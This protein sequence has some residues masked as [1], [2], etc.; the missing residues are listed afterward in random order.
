M[1]DGQI[2]VARQGAVAQ[3]RVLGRATFKISQELKQ[4][5]LKAVQQQNAKDIICDFS[6]CTALDST[7]MGVLAMLGL[8]SRG[9]CA[10]VFVNVSP[11]NRKLLDGLGVSRLF[12]FATEPVPEVT[13]S[14]LCTA[15][16]KTAAASRETAE[17]VLSAHQTLMNVDAGNIPKFRNVVDMLI[18][19]VE[20]LKKEGESS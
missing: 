2:L 5:C 11:A 20:Q 6:E 17:L 9:K 14:T 18:N 4:F 12:R 7:F 13:W 10:I 15:A 16:E 19:E 8:E 3:I 1:A